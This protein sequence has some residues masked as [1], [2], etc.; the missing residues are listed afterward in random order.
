MSGLDMKLAIVVAMSENNAIGVENSLPWHLPEDLK[1]FKEITMGH[2]MIMGRL[3]FDSIGRP[4]P[5]RTTIV[6][7]RNRD[8]DAPDGVL[9]AYCVEDAI[10]IAAIEAERLSV[11]TVMVVGGAKIYEQML[12]ICTK[13]Y[14]T[15]VHTFVTGDAFFPKINPKIWKEVSRL[16]YQSKTSNLVHYSL[17][18]YQKIAFA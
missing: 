16:K 13:L 18:E 4:L 7:T 14:V 12:D 8:W 5:G 2:P 10:K 6:V 9:V 15:E 11:D 3:T 1:R 17:V